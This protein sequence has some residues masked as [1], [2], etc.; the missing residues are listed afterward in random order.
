[1]PLWYYGW[2]VGSKK[3]NKINIKFYRN[4]QIFQNIDFSPPLERG[5][6]Y[7]FEFI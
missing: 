4:L 2:Q 3:R 7:A 1:M 5:V 6:F